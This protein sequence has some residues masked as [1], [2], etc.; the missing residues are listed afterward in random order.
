MVL[1]LNPDYRAPRKTFCTSFGHASRVAFK[2]V[3]GMGRGAR[4][5]SRAEMEHAIRVGWTRGSVTVGRTARYGC[6]MNLMS[7]N[8]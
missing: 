3:A 6:P 1:L 2:R 5:M 4:N 8:G 7:E